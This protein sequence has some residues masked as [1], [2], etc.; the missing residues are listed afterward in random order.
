MKLKVGK[1]TNL[2]EVHKKWINNL[3]ILCINS[4]FAYKFIGLTVLGH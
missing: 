1:N 3:Y 4:I 2:Y